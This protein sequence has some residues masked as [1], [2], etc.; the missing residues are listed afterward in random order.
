[1][2]KC[3]PGRKYNNNSCFTVANLITIANQYN[4]LQKNIREQIAVSKF[5][6]IPST[7]KDKNRK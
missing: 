3:A 7:A 1:M 6:V 4:K 5:P 2:D